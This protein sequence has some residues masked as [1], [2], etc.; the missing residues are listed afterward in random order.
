MAGLGI[1]AIVKNA[2]AVLAYFFNPDVRK[3]RDR[4]HDI[5]Q[6]RKMEKNYRKAL[7]D[8]DPALA[9]RIAKA[10]KDLRAEY[11]FVNKK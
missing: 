9:S 5:G 6:F 2:F 7:A 3:K 1:M 11:K 8:K 10:M 4:K